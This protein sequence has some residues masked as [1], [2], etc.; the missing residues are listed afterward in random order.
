[1]DTDTL[2]QRPGQGRRTGGQ[3]AHTDAEALF[4]ADAVR[5]SSTAMVRSTRAVGGLPALPRAQ[6]TVL[7]AVSARQPIAPS[8][9]A[10]LLG[11]ARPTVSNLVRELVDAELLRR[12]RSATDGRTAGL[13]VTDKARAILDSFASSRT[14]V[15]NL[16]L[17]QLSDSD[18]QA[19]RAAVAALGRFADQLDAIRS[20][21]AATPLRARTAD[22]PTP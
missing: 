17:E 16:A 2:D 3:D 15:V 7:Q 21:Q 12:T 22:V 4:L 19:L 5:R 11:L 20:P 14:Q 10:T 13:A 8:D 1:M 18:R 9:L 6:V